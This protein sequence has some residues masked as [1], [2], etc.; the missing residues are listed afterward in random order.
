M[1]KINI[2]GVYKNVRDASWR[3]LSEYHIDKLPVDVLQIART[4]GIKIIK[5]SSINE[6]SPSESGASL[7]DGDNWY[8]IYD[9][10]NTVQQA[11]FTVAHELGHIFLGHDLR[12]RDQAHT[13]D[14]SKPRVEREADS[15]AARLLA[16]ACVLWGLDLHSAQ[17]IASVCNISPSAAKSRA[18]R[19]TVLYK[20][21]K[22]LTSA[23]EKA[24]FDNFKDYIQANRA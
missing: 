11:R 17:E 21:D 3:C 9:D 22:F 4:A 6:L 12:K 20:R 7:F 13:F 14:T 2:Y 15:F 24:I 10:G 19:M 5:N 18:E 8:I 16:P 1:I 23:L